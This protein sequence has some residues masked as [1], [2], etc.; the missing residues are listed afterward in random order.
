MTPETL[1][2]VLGWCAVIDIGLLAW[3]FAWIALAHDLVYRIHTRWFPMSV[4]RFD[5]IHYGG[6]GAF[7]LLVFAFFVVPYLALRI[8]L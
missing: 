7:K 6:M 8:V 5:A 2:A 3:W 4:E 1:M